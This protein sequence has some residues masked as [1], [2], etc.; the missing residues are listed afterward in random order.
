MNLNLNNYISYLIF[1]D[2][3]IKSNKIY[4]LTYLLLN[5]PIQYYFENYFQYLLTLN[6]Q[7]ILMMS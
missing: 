6:F 4:Y 1:I 5:K 7:F 2:P 3:F